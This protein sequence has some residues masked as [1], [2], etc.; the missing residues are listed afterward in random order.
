MDQASLLSSLGYLKDVLTFDES[1]DDGVGMLN[2]PKRL[3]PRGW[4]SIS[5]SLVKI[6][7]SKRRLRMGWRIVVLLTMESSGPQMG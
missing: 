7:D 1:T 5:K 4:S 2:V 6:L 3:A